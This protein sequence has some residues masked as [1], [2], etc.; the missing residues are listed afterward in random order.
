VFVQVDQQTICDYASGAAPASSTYRYLYASYID[1]PIVRIATSNSETTWYHRN[2][3]YSIV[4]CTDSSGAAT[5]RYAYTAYGLP[6]ITDA[7]GTVRT[8]SAIG[9]RY[10]YTGR[11][12]DGTLGV[13]H[14][15]ARMFEA[16][17]GRFCSRD[18]IG[19]VDGKNLFQ[20]VQ[21]NPTKSIDPL[22]LWEVVV[23]PP[24]VT[25]TVVT[26]TVGTPTSTGCTAGALGC[27]KPP[28]VLL[29]VVCTWGFYELGQSCTRPAL[30][31]VC[32]YFVPADQ[33]APKRPKPKVEYDPDQYDYCVQQAY[34]DYDKVMEYYPQFK[35]TWDEALKQDLLDCFRLYGPESN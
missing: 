25:T 33:P 19:Y 31:K 32:Y 20:Y 29:L 8:S 6:T 21:S 30:T 10:T 16:T 18:P 2:Q 15:R 12:W 34:E 3:Q 26:T 9:N 14:Y 28:Q 35:D 7:S 27:P 22:G 23:V 13:Y 24:T 5:E 17:V 11:E 1:E 4:A